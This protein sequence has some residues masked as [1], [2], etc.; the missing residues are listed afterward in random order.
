MREILGLL[1][2]NKKNKSK[3]HF[4][5]IAEVFGLFVIGRAL[6]GIRPVGLF[7]WLSHSDWRYS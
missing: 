5:R 1:I 3:R 4:F 2:W 6:E 7:L